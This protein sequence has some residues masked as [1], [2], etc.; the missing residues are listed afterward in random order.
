ML[1]SI[2]EDVKR[3]YS[4][5]NMITRLVI[6]N[7]AIFILINLVGVILTLL[8]GYDNNTHFQDIIHFLSIS[9]DAWHDLTHPWAILTHM[10]LH[11]G[12]FHFLFNMLFLYWFG[13]IVQ[14]FIGNHRI[15]PIYLMG[16][17]FGA[18]AFF[19]SIYFMQGPGIFAHGASAAVMAFVVAAGTLAPEYSMRLILLGNVKLK[20]IVF[21][22]VLLDI[23]GLGSNINTGGHFAH[24]GGAFFGWLYVIRLR[25]GTDWAEPINNLLNAITNVFTPVKTAMTGKSSN[26]KVVHKRT[27]GPKK[28][29]PNPAAEDFQEKLDMILDKIKKNGIENLSEEEKEFLFQA[30]KK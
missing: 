20:Y 28:E 12:F 3:E 4:F 11:E 14:D 30:S 17:L 24:L 16:G 22:L 7:T 15:L 23:F 25:E 6:V 9:T 5:G 19:I 29:A 8:K 10:F 13:R 1:N 18:I 26:L 27:P 21:T 2:W